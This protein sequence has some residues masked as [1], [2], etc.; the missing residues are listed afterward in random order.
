MGVREQRPGLAYITRQ[1]GAAA[2]VI[3]AHLIDRLP[4][5]ADAPDLRLRISVAQAIG[6]ATSHSSGCM[7]WSS[8]LACTDAAP[9]VAAPAEHDVAVILYR[10]SP[11]TA[12]AHYTRPGG[13]ESRIEIVCF[14]Y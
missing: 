12:P 8:L 10:R 3:D 4:D 2:I 14:G 6:D 7:A 9:P 13:M 11:F 5:A 1:C